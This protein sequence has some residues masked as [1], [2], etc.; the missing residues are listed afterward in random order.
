MFVRP[1]HKCSLVHG[2]CP[3]YIMCHSC[4]L[5]DVNKVARG[6]QKNYIGIINLCIS[7]QI[8]PHVWWRGLLRIWSSISLYFTLHNYNSYCHTWICFKITAIL[9]SKCSQMYLRWCSNFFLCYSELLSLLS[10]MGFVLCL[11]SLH[12]VVS[13]LV[14]SSS[15]TVKPHSRTLATL[16][17]ALH[18]AAAPTLILRRFSRTRV[19]KRGL[20]RKH[21]DTKSVIV[22]LTRHGSRAGDCQ[23]WM[24]ILISVLEDVPEECFPATSNMTPIRAAVCRARP[25]PAAGLLTHFKETFTRTSLCLCPI[26]SN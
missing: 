5:F 24:V 18:C 4:L 7:N 16:M 22:L 2:Y 9:T 8:L 23:R 20:A 11:R 10:I 3:L 15:L 13:W 19:K 6:F 26:F 12:L 17:P 25:L 14:A 21:L 1:K